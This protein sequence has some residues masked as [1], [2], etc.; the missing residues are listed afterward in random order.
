MNSVNAEMPT[1]SQ[2]SDVRQETSCPRVDEGVTTRFRAKAVMN[3]R[4][5]SMSE[6]TA[7]IY[8]ALC[9]VNNKVYVGSA[10][11]S[12]VRFRDHKREL[13]EQDHN[14]S[15]LQRAWNKY[16][17]ESFTW[18]VVE[19]CS[20]DRRWQREQWW[21]DGL[22]A[23]DPKYG[24]NV[25]HSATQLLPSPVMSK[26]LKK[27]WAERWLDQEYSKRRTEQLREI[28]NRPEVK[29][30]LSSIKLVSWADP[31]YRKMMIAAQTAVASTK[32]SREANR[33]RVTN[34]WQDPEYRAKQLVERAKR[35]KD[36]E[37]RKK[38]SIAAQN[39]KRKKLK[40][41]SPETHNEIV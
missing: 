26:L 4:A 23:C 34:L 37:F 41:V 21:I 36:P 33:K 30:K 25:M 35:F 9:T 11:R 8:V 12:K 32:E 20:L 13:K 19:T 5:P 1:P 18:T 27:Y 39:R 40:T 38:L 29:E 14:N 10:K 3:P 6:E 7:E 28:V 31:E 15:Y 22:G 17:A 16:G 24:F 2:A